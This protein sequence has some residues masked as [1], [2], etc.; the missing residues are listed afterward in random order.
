MIYLNP[1]IV[2]GLGED[3]FWM[4]FRREFPSA[5]FELP[6]QLGSEDIV[7][8]YSTLGFI[9][10]AGKSIG[11][12]WELHPEMKE[13]L[14]S[15]EWDGVI[16]RVN[17][18]AKFSTYRT[19]TSQL[20][21]PFYEQFGTIEVLPIGVNTDLF[22]PLPEK[23]ALRDKYNIPREKPV[24][25]WCGT[26]HPMKGFPKLQE[27]ARLNP[28]IH[29]IIVWKQESE[30][31]RLPGAS[32]FT[33]VSQQTLCELMNA[34][35]FFLS[36]GKLRPFYMVEWEAMACN[37]PARILDNMQ[38]DFTPSDNPRDDIFRLQ[39]DRKSA[40][41]LWADYLLRKGATW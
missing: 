20:M 14:K 38:K 19:V 23:Q 4:W 12:L 1:E 36:C 18:C 37:L 29:W 30:A 3:T 26:T 34:A 28:D 33:T 13:Q 6:K 10:R 8:Q 32:N 15:N 16:A 2:S 5:S 35:D 7:L 21:V 9:N 31:G 11:L 27:Y 22:K 40:R 25:F 17:E 24:G 41:K 39:W